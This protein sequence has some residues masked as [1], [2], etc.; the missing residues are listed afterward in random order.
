[1]LHTRSVLFNNVNSVLNIVFL[2]KEERE[3]MLETLI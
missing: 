1:M 3:K 2:R